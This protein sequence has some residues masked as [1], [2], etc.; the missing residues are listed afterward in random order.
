MNRLSRGLFFVGVAIV[1]LGVILSGVYSTG[2]F[3]DSNQDNPASGK[4]DSQ[5]LSGDLPESDSLSPRSSESQPGEPS[6]RNSD[7]SGSV[8]ER[9]A[10]TSQGQQE[11]QQRASAPEKADRKPSDTGKQRVYIV[12]DSIAVGAT[13]YYKAAFKDAGW[14]VDI[15]ALGGRSLTA[16]PLPHGLQAIEQDKDKIASADSVVIALGTNISPRF[17]QGVVDAVSLVEKTNPDAKLYWVDTAAVGPYADYPRINAV[18]Y[19]QAEALDFEVIPWFATVSPGQLGFV[20]GTLTDE[21]G[22]LADGVHPNSRGYK[23]LTDV[24]VD[25]V[26]ADSRK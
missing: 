9:P 19:A 1:A 11:V 21:H 18:I 17:N 7:A 20:S 26:T 12:G 8:Q 24:V 14:R 22:Y 16:P 25:T 3:G 10:T 5:A 23:A 4:Q 15:N 2:V 13:P 6:S